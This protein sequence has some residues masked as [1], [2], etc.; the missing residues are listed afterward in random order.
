M[1]ISQKLCVVAALAV[2]LIP[3]SGCRVLHELQPHRL[4]RLNRGPD[5]GS[6]ALY[7]VPDPIPHDQTQKIVYHAQSQ[8]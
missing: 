5:I 2:G 6:G 1:G 3:L 8:H 7:S 4:Q